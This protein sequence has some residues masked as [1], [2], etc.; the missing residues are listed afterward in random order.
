MPPSYLCIY[1]CICSRTYL[2][3]G[4][5]IYIF[6]G[7]VVEINEVQGQFTLQGNFVQALETLSSPEAHALAVPAIEGLNAML[8]ANGLEEQADF[9]V[10]IV[11]FRY[12]DN[13]VC[14]SV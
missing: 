7:S 8:N 12:Q 6:T 4:L 11:G 9:N 10:E 13:Y 1:L 5:F 14:S 3:I 2:F